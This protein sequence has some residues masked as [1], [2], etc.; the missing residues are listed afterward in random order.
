MRLFYW[1]CAIKRG[2]VFSS[3]QYQQYVICKPV[4]FLLPVYIWTWDPSHDTIKRLICAFSWQKRSIRTY[5]WK[6]AKPNCLYVSLAKSEMESEWTHINLISVT[7]R[8]NH[9]IFSIKA[10]QLCWRRNHHRNMMCRLL[11]QPWR[12]RSPGGSRCLPG[13]S[14]GQRSQGPPSLRPSPERRRCKWRH[15]RP[16]GG[17][18]M[19]AGGEKRRRGAPSTRHFSHSW[20]KLILLVR[21]K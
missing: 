8:A 17:R 6:Q 18:R 13:N 7:Q 11:T 3:S 15:Q 19:T 14:D 2:E 12:W 20:R 5:F 1:V 21:I 16:T 4:I 10:K 9:I